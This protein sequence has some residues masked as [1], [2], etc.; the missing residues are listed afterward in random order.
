MHFDIK[1]TDCFFPNW[2]W[3]AKLCD[4]ETVDLDTIGISNM[5][6]HPSETDFMQYQEQVEHRKE[7]KSQYSSVNCT[8]RITEEA[9]KTD[10]CVS[11]V[12]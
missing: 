5:D 12:T 4:V 11:A 7:K 2:N 1:T 10:N 8:S 3:K 6:N 9:K